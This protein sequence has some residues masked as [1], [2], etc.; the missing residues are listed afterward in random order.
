[1]TYSAPN[2]AASSVAQGKSDVWVGE[3]LIFSPNAPPA[4][5]GLEGGMQNFKFSFENGLG[6]IILDNISITASATSKVNST[7]ASSS[8]TN[9]TG[10]ASSEKAP[11]VNNT[12]PLKVLAIPLSNSVLLQW[13]AVD[14]AK[15]YIIEYKKK[16]ESK[17]TTFQ[18]GISVKQGLTITGLNNKTEYAFRVLAVNTSSSVGA[19]SAIVTAIPKS[20]LVSLNY[21]NHILSTGQSL[22]I[23]TLGAPALTKTQP[24]DNKML[25]ATA[26]ALIPLIEPTTNGLNNCESM[27]SAMANT[28][29]ALALGYNSIVSLNG[30]SGVAYSVLKKGTPAYK[31]G[32]DRISAGLKMSI[33]DN[34][35][36]KVA[37]ITVVHGE[38]DQKNGR[39]AAEYESYLKQ[40]MTDYQT[41]IQA[42]TGQSDVIPLFTDQNSSWGNYTVA[43]PEVPLGQLNAS[44]NNPGKIILVTPKYTLDYYDNVHLKNYSYRRL[45]EYYGKVM[46]KV[47]VDKQ[48]WIPLSPKTVTI[49]GNI[50][51]VKFNVPVGPLAFDT[52]AVI[53]AANYGFEYSDD[54]NSTTLTGNLSDIVIIAP[55]EIQ[56]K[57]INAPAVGSNPK[58]RYAYTAVK[59]V[60]AGRDIV[61]SPKG[62]L[63]DSDQTPSTY[64]DSR[65]P[66]TMGNFL[67]NWCITFD[68]PI[69]TN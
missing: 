8:N 16:S 23:G 29:S 63:R 43:T 48:P 15:D 22:S 9:V 56:L 1:M 64:Q 67:R 20:N 44:I 25:D 41:D 61:G 59:G 4:T 28:I 68:V 37:A 46:K 57:L 51:K 32:L 33:E 50:I 27:S 26:T 54:S 3:S 45:G 53:K 49:S 2:G 11:V 65:F 17:W 36:Y 42:I 10:L 52:T 62:N 35:P 66:A 31:K 5:Y 47:L 19:P 55:D 58:L 40:W 60:K 38:S 34:K 7:K 21:N 30:V 6:T 18:D 12:V 14:A 13:T 69:L 24:Y 39:T